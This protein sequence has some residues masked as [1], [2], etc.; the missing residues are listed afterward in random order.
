MGGGIGPWGKVE[1]DKD[2]GG[3]I[4]RAVG[5]LPG[6]NYLVTADVGGADGAGPRKIFRE[7]TIQADDPE[8]RLQMQFG[9][10]PPPDGGTPAQR[11]PGRT[12]AD[13]KRELAALGNVAWSKAD[14][15]QPELVWYGLPDGLAVADTKRH[16]LRRYKDLLGVGTFVPAA[17]AFG[18][19][20]VWIGTDKGRIA[21]DRKGQFWARVAVGGTMIE[22]DVTGVSITD[23][24]KL[25]V[26]VGEKGKERRFEYDP[27][28]KKW[29]ALPG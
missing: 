27:G 17:I 4:Y 7:W 14:P 5:L 11:A 26:T 8:P 25:N 2:D 3:V 6:V 23:D 19:E 10:R 28:A 16:E 15:V 22:A 29:S 1:Q 20:K 21:W 18:P 12:E 24:G 9:A 13:L